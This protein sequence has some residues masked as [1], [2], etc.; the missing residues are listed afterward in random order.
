M[1]TQVKPVTGGSFT[2]I[3]KNTVGGADKAT[4]GVSALPNGGSQGHLL[5]A[6]NMWLNAGLVA[7]PSG[8]AAAAVATGGTFAAGA[9]YWK[10]TGLSAGGQESPASAEVTATLVL[11]G[12]ATLTWSA[13]PAGTTGVNV[14]RG[15]APGAENALVATL[16]AGVTYTDTGSAGTAATPPSVPSQT[17]AQAAIK[18]AA[19]VGQLLQEV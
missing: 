1:T 6:I 3:A 10:I 13:L 7:P 4:T 14:Y 2:T 12:S 15:T 11:N 19:S 9:K 18:S 16:G 8:L 17:I 5:R